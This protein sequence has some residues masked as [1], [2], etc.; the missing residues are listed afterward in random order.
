MKVLSFLLLQ[1]YHSARVLTLV[2]Q[3]FALGTL[4]ILAYREAKL[5]TR[6]RN[7][8]GYMLF[9][10]S[11]LLVLVVSRICFP[12][13]IFSFLNIARSGYRYHWFRNKLLRLWDSLF[14]PF[15][16]I[17]ILQQLD[18]ATS[19][20]GGLGTFIGICA[21]SGVFGIA[22]AHVQGGMVGDLSF[23]RP[24]FIQVSIHDCHYY[25]TYSS[26]TCH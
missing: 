17:I 18:L 26:A 7:L 9:F 19:G 8:F 23:M 21:I 6:R 10:I 12:N 20:K 15:I 16:S 13:Q 22:D 1:K 11:S 25:I 5:N 4:A 14:I 3:P 24:E 2:Y